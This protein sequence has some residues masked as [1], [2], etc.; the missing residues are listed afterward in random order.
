[1]RRLFGGGS[2]GAPK[3]SSAEATKDSIVKMRSTLEMLE[4]KEK[5]LDSKI[6][7]EISVARTNA[8]SNKSG[9]RVLLFNPLYYYMR[10]CACAHLFV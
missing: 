1:M 4:K 10:F 9:I 3:K 6:Q 2:S 7:A 8:V 5:H